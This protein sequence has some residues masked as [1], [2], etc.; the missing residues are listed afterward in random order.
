MRRSN[1]VG[2]NRIDDAKTI[3]ILATVAIGGIL[4]MAPKLIKKLV[5]SKK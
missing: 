2:N 3:A 4:L 5:S 1:Y